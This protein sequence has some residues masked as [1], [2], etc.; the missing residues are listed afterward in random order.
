VRYRSSLRNTC[1][2]GGCE[3]TSPPETLELPFMNRIYHSIWNAT[4]ATGWQPRNRTHRQHQPQPHPSGT[5]FATSPPAGLE[6]PGRRFGDGADEHGSS[7]LSPPNIDVAA[8]VSETMTDLTYPDHE[9][10][11]GTIRPPER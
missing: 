11:G 6:A 3:P 5:V 4:W 8:G 7:G 10:A 1:G 2:S 9:F